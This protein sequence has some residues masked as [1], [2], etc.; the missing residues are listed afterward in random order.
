MSTRCQIHVKGSPIL[1]YKHCDGYP[2]GVLPVLKPFAKEF[3]KKKKKKKRGEDP[4][5]CLA[6]IIRA[7]A[8][9]DYINSPEFTP[10]KGY[11]TGWGVD[12]CIHA[13]I[14]F[15]YVVD[16]KKGTVTTQTENFHLLT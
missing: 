3:A 14:E 13:D 8:I 7:F 16:S 5:Y 11:F 4:D 10:K 9:E 1:I 12:T 2:E 6:Q 15:L